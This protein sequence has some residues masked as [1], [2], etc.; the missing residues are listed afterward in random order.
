M[1]R[2]DNT[3]DGF[4]QTNKLTICDGIVKLQTLLPKLFNLSTARDNEL[5]ISFEFSSMGILHDND[6]SPRYISWGMCEATLKITYTGTLDWP[7]ELLYSTPKA[8]D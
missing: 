8:I 2:N 4:T 6:I 5:T 1:A 7:I 3:P